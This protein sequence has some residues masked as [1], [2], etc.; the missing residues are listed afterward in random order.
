MEGGARHPGP[1]CRRGLGEQGLEA[2]Q[3]GVGA[4]GAAAAG[5]TQATSSPPESKERLASSGR[6]PEARKP[7]PRTASIR[8]R[9]AS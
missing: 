7:W 2:R 8:P 9:A 3:A 1:L 6:Q 5:R 4:V